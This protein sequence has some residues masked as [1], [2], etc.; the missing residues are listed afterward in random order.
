MVKTESGWL[1][2]SLLQW[3]SVSGEVTQKAFERPGTT[4]QLR[5]STQHTATD[6]VTFSQGRAAVRGSRRLGPP[7]II[8]TKIQ[9]RSIHKKG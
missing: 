4:G 7:Q 3:L 5:S 2:E 9:F 1:V 8:K 6:P